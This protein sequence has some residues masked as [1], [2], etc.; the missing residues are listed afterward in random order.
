[1]AAEY[2]AELT[3]LHVAEDAQHLARAE[4]IISA[5]TV[6]LDKLISEDERKKL[7]VRA[8]VRFGKPYEQIVRHAS[9]TQTSLIIMTARGGD[10][11]DRA[12]FGSTTYR[13]IQ[14]G[15]CPVL[16]VHT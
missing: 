9:E 11:L 4:A 7:N 2:A 10:A 5:R 6:Q 15:P 16:A 8:A 13:V 3:I 1:L 12:V 14:L